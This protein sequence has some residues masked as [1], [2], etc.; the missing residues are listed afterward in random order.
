MKIK[1]RKLMLWIKNNYFCRKNNMKAYKEN[2]ISIK[3]NWLNCKIKPNNS[4]NKSKIKNY[5]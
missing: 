4:E 3:V 1:S 2:L 5:Y